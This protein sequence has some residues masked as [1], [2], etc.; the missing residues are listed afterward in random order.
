MYIVLDDGDEAHDMK[1][2]K[3]MLQVRGETH[4]MKD[5]KGMLQVRPNFSM[6][7]SEGMDGSEGDAASEIHTKEHR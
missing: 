5:E 7:M 6:D 3:G 1:D 2:E 4:D